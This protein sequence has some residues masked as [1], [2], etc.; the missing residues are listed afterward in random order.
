MGKGTQIQTDPGSFQS[1]ETHKK[2]DAIDARSRMIAS[3]S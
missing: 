1:K 3:E 2:N